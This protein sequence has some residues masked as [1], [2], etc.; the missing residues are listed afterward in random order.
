MPSSGMRQQAVLHQVVQAEM[1]HEALPQRG[2]V[3]GGVGGHQPAIDR[4]DDVRVLVREEQVAQS[5]AAEG[6]EGLR[7]NLGID[8]VPARIEQHGLTIVHDE[9]LV[10]LHRDTGTAGV[11]KQDVT[12]CAVVE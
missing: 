7:Q 3:R 5:A 2:D 12:V 4:S 6:R 10:R 9:V 11:L 1:R 8:L